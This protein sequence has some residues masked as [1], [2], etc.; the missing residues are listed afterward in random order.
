MT[1]KFEF[2]ID[3]LKFHFFMLVLRILEMFPQMQVKFF[4]LTVD[5]E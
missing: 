5:A 1:L 2:W 4:M 3:V